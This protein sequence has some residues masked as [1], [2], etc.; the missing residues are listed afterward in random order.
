[1][2][3]TDSKA[4]TGTLLSLTDQLTKRPPALVGHVV[5]ASLVSAEEAER[6]RI[7][8]VPVRSSRHDV[9]AAPLQLHTIL[10]E[11]EVVRNIVPAL[12]RLMVRLNVP[13][14]RIR[15]AGAVKIRG[16]VMHVHSRDLRPRQT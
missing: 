8:V 16:R 9:P 7:A 5:T 2:V 1:T 3:P 13:P 12:S 15:V 11:A 14:T 4:F 6:D 10:R